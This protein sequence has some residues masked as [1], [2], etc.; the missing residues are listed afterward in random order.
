MTAQTLRI[1]AFVRDRT[2]NDTV[3]AWGYNYHGQAAR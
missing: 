3:R 2:C 1:L